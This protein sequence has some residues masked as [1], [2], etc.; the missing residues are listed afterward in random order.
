MATISLLSVLACPITVAA[1]DSNF[2][3]LDYSLVMDFADG[4]AS[5]MDI[6]AWTVMNFADGSASGM[7]ISAI[8][9][10]CPWRWYS[11]HQNL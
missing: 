11:D 6:S 10:Q 3:P 5:G 8:L 9:M 2:G 1:L 7:D 4:S